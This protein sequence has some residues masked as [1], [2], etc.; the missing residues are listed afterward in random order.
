MSVTDGGRLPIFVY[1]TL[2]PGEHNH[3]LFLR[4]R[5]LS[6]RPATMRGIVLYDGPGYPYAVEEPAGVVH[7]ELVAALPETYAELLGALDR[8]EEYVPGDPRNLYERVVRD[9]T[10]ADGTAT[11][12]WVYVAAPAVTARLRAHGRLVPGGDWRER[13]RTR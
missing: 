13:R 2:R 5:T 10:R 3:D 7:G 12:A 9:V 1:G 4:G 11:R 8:L 6:E